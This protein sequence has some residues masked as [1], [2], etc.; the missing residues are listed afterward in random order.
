MKWG[1]WFWLAMKY[2][3]HGKSE[4][5]NDKLSLMTSSMKW[6][7]W[8]AL[9]PVQMFMHKLLRDMLRQYIM[10]FHWYQ[11]KWETHFVLLQEMSLFSLASFCQNGAVFFIQGPVILY[12]FDLG[13][14][15]N[16]GEIRTVLSSRF[17]LKQVQELKSC[18]WL[19]I[20]FVRNHISMRGWTINWDMLLVLGSFR[21]VWG[22]KQLTLR[23][24]FSFFFLGF[25]R[26]FGLG[27][28][29]SFSAF[30]W[31]LLILLSCSWIRRRSFFI[32]SRW[33]SSCSAN[34]RLSWQ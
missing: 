13:K 30:S 5:L 27:L 17:V 11:W 29:F 25:L 20:Q 14:K 2:C 32:S 7:P 1:S 6:A 3:C 22:P 33:R 9:L 16:G 24:G 19:T 21:A 26:I 4:L 10:V 23:S 31:F 15:K 8:C 34:C 12:D 18:V 28:V